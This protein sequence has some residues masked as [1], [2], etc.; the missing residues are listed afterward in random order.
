MLCMLGVHIHGFY[1][2]NGFG[3]AQT[4]LS[5]KLSGSRLWLSVK[6]CE[7]CWEKRQDVLVIPRSEWIVITLAFSTFIH[8]F[9]TILEIA[10]VFKHLR[11]NTQLNPVSWDKPWRNYFQ[12][13]VNVGNRWV[14]RRL[15]DSL[16]PPVKV[17]KGA[18][19]ALFMASSAISY[20]IQTETHTYTDM[21]GQQIG[22]NTA[23]QRPL[24][25]L[26]QSRHLNCRWVFGLEREALWWR[27]VPRHRACREGRAAM[28]NRRP[29]RFEI[30]S[31]WEK[32]HP[33]ENPKSWKQIQ[34]P[35]E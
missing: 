30:I 33:T 7:S 25:C 21:H 2:L 6:G 32:H 34:G 8:S 4:F 23:E 12:K 18:V 35:K 1:S 24:T 14:S 31:E 11:S 10:K 13:L 5:L 29:S 17:T 28:K 26:R 9:A 19:T 3:D 27:S 20:H 15:K 22:G 16:I